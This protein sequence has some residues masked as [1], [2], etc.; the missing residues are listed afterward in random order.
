MLLLG[1]LQ[2]LIYSASVGFM[3]ISRTMPVG[4]LEASFRTPGGCFI[5]FRVGADKTPI[6]CYRIPIGCLEVASTGPIGFYRRHIG[7]IYDSKRMFMC[8]L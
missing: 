8:I 5:I 1:F 3:L 6:G 2:R 7:S 4:L